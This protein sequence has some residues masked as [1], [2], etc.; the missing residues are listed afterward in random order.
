MWNLDEIIKDYSEDSILIGNNKVCKGLEEIRGV[1]ASLFKIFNNGRNLINPE[2][3]AK[4]VIYI[5]W[6]FTPK[7]DE[8]YF[9]SDSFVVENGI[10]TYQT[11]ASLLYKKYPIG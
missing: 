9:G 2:A 8:T 1:F 7:D 3:I 4:K 5:T 6:N 10:V 11:V